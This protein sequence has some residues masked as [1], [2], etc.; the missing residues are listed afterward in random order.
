MPPMIGF[1]RSAL[2]PVAGLKLASCFCSIRYLTG[3]LRIGGGGL[4]PSPRGKPR[5]SCWRCF[6][7][8]RNQLW[9]RLGSGERAG[10]NAKL[11]TPSSFHAFFPREPSLKS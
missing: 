5:K 11:R 6:G 9:L 3:E 8:W 2:F 4:L 10:A 7:P 1:S